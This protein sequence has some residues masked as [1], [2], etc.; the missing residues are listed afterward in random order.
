MDIVPYLVMEARKE[1]PW[2]QSRVSSASRPLFVD[3][4]QLGPAQCKV[5]SNCDKW[6]CGGALTS[7]IHFQENRRGS[8][9]QNKSHWSRQGGIWLFM[10]C[11]SHRNHT[12][13]VMGLLVD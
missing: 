6:V 3:A 1:P 11:G 5:Q 13:M 4:A 8:G 12:E 2:A 7:S 9:L 10:H